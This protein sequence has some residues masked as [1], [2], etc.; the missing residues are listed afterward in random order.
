MKQA[1][2]KT[3]VAVVFLLFAVTSFTAAQTLERGAIHGFVYDTSGS[4]VPGVKITLTS[5]ATGLKRELTSDENGAY[6]FEAL[7][8]GEYTVAFESAAFNTYTVKGIKVSVGSS[9]SLDANMKIKT[10]E[11]N[12]VVTA[13]AVGIVDTSTSGIS[14]VLDTTSLQELPFPGR[15][16][17]DLAQLTPSAQVTPGLRGAIRLGGQQSDYN[18]LVIDGADS[19]NN[20]FGENFGSL[21]TKNLTVPIESVQEFQ[22]VTNG[23]APEFGRATGGLLNVVTKSG[24][25]EIHGEA[26]EYYRGSALTKDDALGAPSNIDKQN[27]FGGSVGFPIHKDRQWLFLSTDVQRN[28][29][30]LTTTLCHG[31]PACINDAGPVIGPQT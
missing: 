25:N 3:A 19:T 21:E 26:H 28:N 23:F 5:S 30:P 10:A 2:C 16:Y 9:L 18:G 27:Q 1:L 29:G 14:Q 6:D 7:I 20:F 4:A 22:V 13:D 12:I 24:T 15:D 17:R 8:P 31:D 11:Q